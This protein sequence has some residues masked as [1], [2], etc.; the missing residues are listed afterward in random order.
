MS[1]HLVPL[2]KAERALLNKVRELLTHLVC[3][4]AQICV[5]HQQENELAQCLHIAL[6]VDFFLTL[7]FLKGCHY[8]DLLLTTDGLFLC[9]LCSSV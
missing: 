2:S 6:S 7:E 5:L 9:V 4:F 8:L 1:K 3:S